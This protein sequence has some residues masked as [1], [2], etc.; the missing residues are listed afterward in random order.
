[1]C[2][3]LFG[4]TALYY[5][6]YAR[7]VQTRATNHLLG[8]DIVYNELKFTGV[9]ARTYKTHG[10]NG[11]SATITELYT[12]GYNK[13]QQL[14]V[15]T[16]SLNSGSSV[17]LALNTYDELGILTTKKRHTNSDTETFAYN[18]RNWTTN[19]TS[20]GFTEN[21]YYNANPLN[22]NATYNGNISYST[23]TYNGAAKGYLYEYDGLNRLLSAN[24]KQVSSGLGDDSFNEAFTYYK[25]G[26]TI[27]LQR[28][29][30][31][32]LIDDLT[33]HYKNGEKSYEVDEMTVNSTLV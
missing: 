21:L 30:N 14:Q 17:V 6:K 32:V 15:T 1:M 5:D 12:Y 10:I 23:C 4:V 31:N 28:K 2:L 29:K 20:G 33:L 9:P 16:Y 27:T 19:I 26:N 3:F 13:A 24:F 22:S 8:Y 7:V 18:V 11:A 25:M